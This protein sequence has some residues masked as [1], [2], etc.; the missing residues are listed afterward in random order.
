M[1]LAYFLWKIKVPQESRT[2]SKLNHL[3]LG[4]LSTFTE[5]SQPDKITVTQPSQQRLNMFY[6]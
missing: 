2:I 3:F 4:L 5:I 1:I 6:I